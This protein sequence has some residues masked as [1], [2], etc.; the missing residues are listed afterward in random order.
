MGSGEADMVVQGR[1]SLG[2]GGESPERATYLR[3][4]SSKVEIL[5]DPPPPPGGG[6]LGRTWGSFEGLS[7]F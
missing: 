1:G 5:E 6:G 4:S 3:H 2:R 7:M